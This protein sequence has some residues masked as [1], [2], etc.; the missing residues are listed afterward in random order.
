MSRLTLPPTT[1]ARGIRALVAMVERADPF[2]TGR[3]ERAMS[4]LAQS[5]W[6]L[7]DRWPKAKSRIMAVVSAPDPTDP[8]VL[9]KAIEDAGR[10]TADLN[11]GIKDDLTDLTGQAW[12]KGYKSGVASA[13][14]VK[15]QIDPDIPGDAIATPPMLDEVPL[16]DYVDPVA[17]FTV[18]D[19]RAF[20]WLSN[21]T[22]FWIR[23]A[24]DNAL[25]GRIATHARSALV[26]GLGRRELA[27]QLKAALDQ[28]D[29]PISYWNVVSSASM[30]RARS[31]GSVSGMRASGVITFRY[32]AIMDRRT[33]P[34]CRDMNGKIF[35]IEQGEEHIAATTAVD[36]QELKEVSPWV[37]PSFIEGK[38][39]DELAAAGV[40]M[41]PLHGNCRS[42]VV[43]E[44]FAPI[45][46]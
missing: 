9:D 22:N 33:S 26:T 43:A 2:G 17:P 36:G 11:R 18:A 14:K 25:G 13:K 41:P 16:L 15:R 12:G 21:D 8:A 38:S 34:L 28:F 27:K 7:P 45:G 6:D 39:T 46:G 40:I 30:V 29:E 44:S 35:T 23:D 37:A 42:T 4:M 20:E 32:R 31:F 24:W 5:R 1:I 3:I 10:I 19:V